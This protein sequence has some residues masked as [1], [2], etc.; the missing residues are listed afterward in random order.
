M[1]LPPGVDDTNDEVHTC[2]ALHP[3]QQVVDLLDRIH[4]LLAYA[5]NHKTPFDP[6]FIRWTARF[7]RRNQNASAVRITERIA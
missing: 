4:V 1:D 6:R 2:A 7:D 5:V 3:R